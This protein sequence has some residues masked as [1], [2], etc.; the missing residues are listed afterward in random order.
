MGLSYEKIPRSEYPRPQMTRGQAFCGGESWLNLNGPWQFEFDFGKSGLDRKW[1]EKGGFTKEIIVPFCPESSLSGIGYKDFI[2]AVWYRRVVNLTEAQ[3]SGEVLLHFGAVDYY[4]RVYVNGREAYSHSGGYSS[5][6]APITGFA[7]PGEN[8]IVVYAEDDTRSGKQPS[9]KQSAL[10]Y[11]HGCDYTRTT[12]IWQTV[13]LEFVPKQY[14]KGFKLTPDSA[15]EAVYAEVYIAGGS[16]ARACL[17]GEAFFDGK[18]VGAA[19]ARVEGGFAALRIS[20]AEK[21]LWDLGAPNLYGLRLTLGAGTPGGGGVLEKDAGVIDQAE[22]YFGLRSVYLRDN[23]V[24]LNGRP[25]FQRLV[26]DQGFYPDGIYTAPSDEALKRDIELAQS[27]GFNGARLHEKAFEERFLYHADKMGYLVWGEH[28]NW[29]LNISSPEGLIHFL[30]EWLELV[31]RDFSH[32]AVIG[33]CPFNE[34]WDAANGARQDSRILRTVYEATKALDPTRPVI[35]TSG[36]FHVVTDIYDVH[37]YEQDVA[38][39]AG[40]YKGLKKGEIHETIPERQRYGG[41]PFF[42]SE[43]GGAWWNPEAGEEDLRDLEEDKAKSWGYGNAPDSEAEFLSRYIGLTEALLLSEGICA[44]CYTQL[45][46]VEQ[47]QNGLFTYGRQPKFSKETYEQI[48][49]TNAQQA[50]VE[51]GART[52]AGD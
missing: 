49:K 44:F 17:K 46:D 5:F 24:F 18:A 28:A 35:D 36:N 27:L 39:F 34:T 29:G 10:F 43:Y 2:P 50:A 22:S 51:R 16:G 21:H 14:I 15:N 33:W 26:L 31:R 11:S 38:V 47:E 13:W 3:L 20:L 30:P 1:Y 45:Y 8:V 42:V 48:K 6:T 4:C 25:V 23:A 37:D 32:P 7:V 52:G 41:Q 40:H 12:G 19:E 9:G